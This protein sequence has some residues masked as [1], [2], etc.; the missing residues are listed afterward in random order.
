M[1]NWFKRSVQMAYFPTKD[2]PL[3]EKSRAPIKTRDWEVTREKEERIVSLRKAHIKRGKK[4][5]KRCIIKRIDRNG[6]SR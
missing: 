5:L 1:T 3:K 2:S 4:K 6:T